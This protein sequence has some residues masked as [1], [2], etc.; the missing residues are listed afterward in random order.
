MTA[1]RLAICPS[2]RLPAVD[3]WPRNRWL[4]YDDVLASKRT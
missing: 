2:V 4:N 3:N 1:V